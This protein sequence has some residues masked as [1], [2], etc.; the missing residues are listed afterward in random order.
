MKELQESDLQV[1][2]ILTF[3][4][5]DF[6]YLRLYSLMPGIADMGNKEKWMPAAFYLLLYMIPWFDPGDDPKNYK[7]IYHAAIW[8]NVN[9]YRGQ[10]REP[11]NENRIVQAGTSGI[12]Q[13][14]M[15]A[16]LRGHGVK[17]IYVYRRKNNP[18][19][20]EEAIT[21][22]TRDFYDDV[23]IPYAYE[24]AWLLAVIC[25]MRYPDG[26]L[27]EL[28]NGY[29]PAYAADMM[30][31]IIQDW[32]DDYNANHEKE[33]VVCSTLVSMI[34]K[35]A[36]FELDVEVLKESGSLAIPQPF[37]L[38]KEVDVDIPQADL[39]GVNVKGTIVTPRQLAESPDVVEVGYLPFRPTPKVDGS[40]Q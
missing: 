5:E 13:A 22:A 33:M 26:K 27:R 35:N 29:M 23:S 4:N 9:I 8:G 36:G 39:T 28:L 34:Y 24:T 12:G 10:N 21:K 7:N 40:I 11:Q 19:G 1:G 16:T 25:T 30:I 3:E 31:L 20:F 32:I 6:S 38:E 37:Q 15:D 18:A 17:N 14:D 2:D